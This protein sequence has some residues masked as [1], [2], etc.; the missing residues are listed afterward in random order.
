MPYRQLQPLWGGT[1]NLKMLKRIN[2][3]HSEKLYEPE[4]L[5]EA[6]NLEQI[7]LSGC[8]NLQ[9]FPAIIQMQKTPSC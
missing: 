3:R 6:I 1:K 4:E 8:K 2:L 9:S 5:S 7:D